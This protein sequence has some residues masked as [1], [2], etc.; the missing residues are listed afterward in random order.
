MSKK[1]IL[2]I[3]STSTSL[4]NFRGDFLKKLKEEG[5]DVYVAAGHWRDG[6]FETLEKDFE[7][8]PLK[9]EL[10][11]TGLNPL[12]DLRTIAQLKRLIKDNKIDLVF[13]YTVKPVIY[14]SIAAN[15]NNVPVVSLIT[16]LGFTFTGLTTKA[17]ILQR[18]NEFLY[19]RYVRKNKAIIFQNKDDKQLFLDRKVLT[20]ANRI[21]VVSGSGVNL[22]RFRFKK[23]YN[24]NSKISFLLIARLI[25]EK[26]IGLYI[27]AAKALKPKYP[28]AEFHVI[29]PAQD[30]P[31]AIKVEELNTL[32]NN[33]TLIW[34]GLQ[35]NI[36]EHL[37]EKDVFVLPSYYRE[38]V[39]RSILEALSVGLPIITTDSPG[40]RETVKKDYNGF[41]VPPKQLEELI[42]TME[43]FI[44][45]TDKVNEMGKNSR[46]YAE[47]R[48]DVDII[49]KDL[50]RIIKSVM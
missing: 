24:Q 26:G 6:V 32:N 22:D 39:P 7:V 25:K 12:N 31:S 9:Y 10:Q 19:R 5:F 1:R 13:P 20:S 42:E 45:N 28:N 47:E 49:N 34:H 14:S 15:A 41:L 16:G 48:F 18:L 38:G 43:F 30:S 44:K 3:G 50:I 27:E 40:C 8:T 21:E 46:N 11:R 4:I 37:T 33:G 29:G 17:K 36:V 35:K 23:D 2:V